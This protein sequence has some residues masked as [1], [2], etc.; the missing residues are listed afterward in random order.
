[1]LLSKELI[2]RTY[3]QKK[4]YERFK[5]TKN[6]YLLPNDSNILTIPARNG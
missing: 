4:A 3:F 2:D 1:M 6:A 5:E